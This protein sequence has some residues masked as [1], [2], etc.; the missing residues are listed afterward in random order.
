MALCVG[1]LAVYWKASL[2]VRTAHKME[3]K[4]TVN[5][6]GQVVIGR[7]L[8]ISFAMFKER[9]SIVANRVMVL[10]STCITKLHI[11][12]RIYTFFKVCMIVSRTK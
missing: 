6:S 3:K 8:F 12:F 4:G 9:G 10:F 7:G 5:L 11:L 2:D 1:V